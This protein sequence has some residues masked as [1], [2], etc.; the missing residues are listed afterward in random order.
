[1]NFSNE[2]MIYLINTFQIQMGNVF[3]E[4]YLVSMYVLQRVHICINISSNILSSMMMCKWYK[5]R[6]MKNECTYECTVGAD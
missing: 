5:I 2:D 4:R 3:S 1:M 6:I